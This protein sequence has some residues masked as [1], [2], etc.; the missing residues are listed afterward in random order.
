MIELR[1][2][3][4]IEQ[5]RAAGVFVASVLTRTARGVQGRQSTCSS[6]TRSR[7][8]LIRA[9]GRRELLHRL[10]PVVRRDRRSARCICTSVNDAVLHGLPHD[11][12]LQDGDLLSLDF[13]AS[14]DGWV[15]RLGASRSSSARR[16]TRTCG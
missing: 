6:S 4:E 7:T 3:A 15:G 9:R 5:M 16:A 10:P 12:A 8:T 1:T 14:V 13:A 2:P 11:Y